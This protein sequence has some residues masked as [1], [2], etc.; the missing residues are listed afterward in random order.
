MKNES[1]QNQEM[2]ET[3]EPLEAQAP[4]KKLVFNPALLAKYSKK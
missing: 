2:K 3:T 1:E 4:P